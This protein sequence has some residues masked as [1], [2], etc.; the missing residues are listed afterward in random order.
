[1]QFVIDSFR[2]NYLAPTGPQIAAFEKEL[3]NR[4][5]VSYAAAT[6]SGTAALHLALT[7]L[8][9]EAGDKVVVPSDKT[10]SYK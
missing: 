1:M 4:V 10:V 9:I 7:A 8:G 3:S 6:S 2:S 5:G